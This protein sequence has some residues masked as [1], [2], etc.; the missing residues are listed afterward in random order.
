MKKAEMILKVIII[1]FF[2]RVFRVSQIKGEG[3]LMKS[4]E[5]F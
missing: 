2:F 4:V 3:K 5:S 1:G